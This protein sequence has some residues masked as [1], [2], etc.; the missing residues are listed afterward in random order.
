MSFTMLDEA[1]GAPAAPA[2]P[3]YVQQPAKVF[4]GGNA[5]Q[6]VFQGGNVPQKV[7][8]NGTTQYNVGTQGRPQEAY[9]IARLQAMV[10]RLMHENQTQRAMA[11]GARARRGMSVTEICVVVVA[12]VFLVLVVYLISLVRSLLGR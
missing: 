12:L 1:W 10:Q 9:E 4:A 6:K 7:F 2:A 5:P 8:E 11:N 3:Q